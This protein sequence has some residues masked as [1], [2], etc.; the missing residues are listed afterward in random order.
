MATPH[1]SPRP[2]SSVPD[3][4]FPSPLALLYSQPYT[5]CPLHS[6]I[7]TFQLQGNPSADANLCTYVLCA[8]AL[9][10]AGPHPVCSRMSWNRPAPLGSWLPP[11]V[12]G[13]RLWVSPTFQL[14]QE[15]WVT[16]PSEVLVTLSTPFISPGENSPSCD[17]THRP[18]PP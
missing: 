13:A 7:M 15:A 5:H 11:L 12:T 18:L 9:T 1:P 17:S 10:V 8:V 6:P 2:C 14:L 16:C 4:V 3:H